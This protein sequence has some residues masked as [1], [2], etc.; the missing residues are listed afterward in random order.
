MGFSSHDSCLHDTCGAEGK[1]CWF[2]IVK[3]FLGSFFLICYFC[4]I[5]IDEFCLGDVRWRARNSSIGMSSHFAKIH[6]WMVYWIQELRSIFYCSVLLDYDFYS[7]VV[8]VSIPLCSFPLWDVLSKV[9]LLMSSIFG[10]WVAKQ[11]GVSWANW[12]KVVSCKL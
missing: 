12:Y 9:N 8:L 1:W 11:E 2:E 10:T 6:V 7:L 5:W 3:R 4:I